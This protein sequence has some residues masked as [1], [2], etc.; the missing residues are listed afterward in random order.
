MWS[1]TGYILASLMT[2]TLMAIVCIIVYF[3]WKILLGLAIVF[4][5]MVSFK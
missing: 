3:S 5:I 2:I 1:K 4:A